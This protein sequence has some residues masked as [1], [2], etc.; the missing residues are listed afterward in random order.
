MSR[1]EKYEERLEDIIHS[2]MRT[3]DNMPDSFLEG[4]LNHSVSWHREA[5]KRMLEQRNR[6]S[7][8]L[9]LNEEK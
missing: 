4:Q 3:W 1:R 8:K 5:A 7:S 9:N 6:R 2:H